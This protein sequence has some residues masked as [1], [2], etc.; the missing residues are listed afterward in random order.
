ML[1]FIDALLIIITVQLKRRTQA[2]HLISSHSLDQ[3]SLHAEPGVCPARGTTGTASCTWDTRTVSGSMPS[4]VGR[5][6]GA[7]DSMQRIPPSPGESGREPD[8][9]PDLLCYSPCC[10]RPWAGGVAGGGGSAC[11]SQEL[12]SLQSGARILGTWGSSTWRWDLPP[13]ISERESKQKEEKRGDLRLG[14]GQAGGDD[15]K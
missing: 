1:D 5:Q 3:L 7:R 13:L 4:S 14:S 2:L 8:P 15:C 10:C 11:G 6:P 12:Q 9:Y